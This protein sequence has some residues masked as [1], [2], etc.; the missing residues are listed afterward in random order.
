[1]ESPI[2]KL[3]QPPFG[4]DF[5]HCPIWD[6]QLAPAHRL[7]RHFDHAWAQA[8]LEALPRDVLFFDPDTEPTWLPTAAAIDAFTRERRKAEWKR[9]GH[10]GRVPK[11]FY[12][13]TAPDNENAFLM[14]HPKGEPLHWT[15]WDNGLVWLWCFDPRGALAIEAL[16]PTA[17]TT[18]QLSNADGRVDEVVLSQPSVSIDRA[19]APYQARELALLEEAMAVALGDAEAVAAATQTYWDTLMSR[20]RKER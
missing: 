6:V 10:R 8:E 15:V 5:T 18:L 13:V 1:M 20:F 17:P 3:S 9:L 7:A 16:V 12:G 14:H 2:S 19:Q 11:S 4:D